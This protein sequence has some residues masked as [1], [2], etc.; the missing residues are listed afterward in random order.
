MSRIITSPGVEVREKDLSL[1]IETVAGTEV[2]V[3]GFASQGPTTEPVLITSVSEL[4]SVFGTPKTPAET[5]L[6]YSCRE[7]LNSPAKL[8]VLRL[9]YGADGGS[10][11]SKSYSGLFYPTVLK[12]GRAH[13]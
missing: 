3:P 7:V 10:D 8:N 12:I 6:Y 2:V 9:P 4:E 1:R 11:Y 5:Y 13:V